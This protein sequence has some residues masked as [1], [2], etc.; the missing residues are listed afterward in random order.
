MGVFL[1]LRSQP[2]FSDFRVDN[3]ASQLTFLANVVSELSN[4]SKQIT[5]LWGATLCI[6]A[7]P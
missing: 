6:L 5:V 1:H 7:V 4:P 2:L 3:R